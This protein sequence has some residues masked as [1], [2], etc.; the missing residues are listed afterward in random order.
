MAD[1]RSSEKQRAHFPLTL[2]VKRS[3][4]SISIT[5]PRGEKTMSELLNPRREVLG[6]RTLESCWTRVLRASVFSIIGG[7]SLVLLAGTLMT[8]CLGRFGALPETIGGPV[9]KTNCLAIPRISLIVLYVKDIYPGDRKDVPASGYYE[10]AKE[11]R[12]R[13]PHLKSRDEIDALLS[14]S[15]FSSIEA[16]CQFGDDAEAWRDACPRPDTFLGRKDAYPKPE[17]MAYA[18]LICDSARELGLMG[19]RRT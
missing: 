4:A 3:A 18:W 7:R 9:G 2:V 17:A 1:V 16:A 19:V 6:K 11:Y 8:G 13:L 12:S 14:K 15:R 10:T 5:F